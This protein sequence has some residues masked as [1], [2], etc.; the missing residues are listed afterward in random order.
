VDIY[1]VLRGLI[2]RPCFWSSPEDRILP[3]LYRIPF[4]EPSDRVNH[5]TGI[6]NKGKD[7]QSGKAY[8]ASGGNQPPFKGTKQI[9]MKLLLPL[10]F[11]SL[12]SAAQ[13][14]PV[15][16]KDVQTVPYVDPRPPHMKGYI[17]I[18]ILS[19]GDTLKVGG[20][21]TLGKGSLPN[22]DFNYIA[23]PSNS[24]QA[25]LKRT[26]TLKEMKIIELNRKGKEKYGYRYYV[27]LEGGY[28]VQVEN[29]IATGEI[30][31]TH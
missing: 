14:P 30:V 8:P 27:K 13:Q 24:P 3:F 17:N 4:I 26:T 21:I 31:L 16:I 6:S 9:E 11:F 29:A 1:L 25:K 10:L 20:T 15:T 7:C 28:L 19:T 5:Y 18:M 23:T 2:Y 22:G 12:A